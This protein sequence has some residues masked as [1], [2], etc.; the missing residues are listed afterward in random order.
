MSSPYAP[1][2]SL[3]INPA[4]LV[5]GSPQE[6]VIQTRDISDANIDVTNAVYTVLITPA[7]GI[8]YTQPQYTSGGQY[9]FNILAT[10]RGVYHISI[11][12]TGPGY[13]SEIKNSPFS[14][15]ATGAY[16][17]TTLATGDGVT[18]G[19][20][21]A[22]APFTVITRGEQGEPIEQGG[23]P[24]TALAVSPSQVATPIPLID[25]DDGTYSGSYTP[26]VAGKWWVRILLNGE[27]VAGVP[28][29]P[30]FV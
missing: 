13:S 15:I 23:A 3:I 5:T 10:S 24:L 9:K 4:K 16:Y 14:M 22:L 2:C 25:N 20:V 17:N 7:A 12:L 6:Y 27:A 1:S 30:V 8:T 29:R 18:G 19:A 21:S 26:D 28:Y 11:N